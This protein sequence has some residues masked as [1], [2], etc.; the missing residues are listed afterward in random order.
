MSRRGRQIAIVEGVPRVREALHALLTRIEAELMPTSRETL[1]RCC[2]DTPERLLVDLRC[3]LFEPVN[4]SGGGVRNVAVT[5]VD[6]V[7]VLT[8]EAQGALA[9]QQIRELTCPSFQLGSIVS[10]VLAFVNALF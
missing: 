1:Q 3:E 10:S 2:S 8:V 4:G 6:R 9:S 7:L 5:L